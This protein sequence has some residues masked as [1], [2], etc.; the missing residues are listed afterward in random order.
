MTGLLGLIGTGTG[1]LAPGC[2]ASAGRGV[3]W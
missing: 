2:L 3:R 1:C